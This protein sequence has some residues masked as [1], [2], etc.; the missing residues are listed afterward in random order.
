MSSLAAVSKSLAVHSVLALPQYVAGWLQIRTCVV[1]DLGAT[2]RWQQD[3]G[4]RQ[5]ALP[6]HDQRCARPHQSATSCSTL[7]TNRHVFRPVA[8]AAAGRKATT[9]ER[10]S[11]M[12]RRLDA[13]D[14]MLQEVHAMVRGLQQLPAA[15]ALP[16]PLHRHDI[17]GPETPSPHQVDSSGKT[18]STGMAGV[19][20]SI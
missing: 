13:S 11:N 15:N 14:K 18:R 2:A 8:G 4:R 17:R 20:A 1:D 16:A 12:E 6:L 19:L 10:L 3:R 5:A 9:E 7:T